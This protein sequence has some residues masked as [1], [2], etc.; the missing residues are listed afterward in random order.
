MDYSKI[1]ERPV[2][3]KPHKRKWF[4]KIFFL[5]R[6]TEEKKKMSFKSWEE[7][8]EP[9]VDFLYRDIVLEVLKKNNWSLRDQKISFKNFMLLIYRYGE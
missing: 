3:E 2:E 1:T 7:E 9:E 5:N 6:R 8:F 4:Q